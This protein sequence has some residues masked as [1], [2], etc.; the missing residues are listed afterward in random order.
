MPHSLIL[1]LSKRDI[2]SDDEQRLLLAIFNKGQRFKAGDEIIADGSRPTTSLILSD[3]LVG[4][5]KVLANGT[6]Q[7]T[8]LH[9]PGDF[10][11]LHGFLLKKMPHGVV[12]FTNSVIT[13]VD[14]SALRAITE[15]AP[16][17][18]RMLWL[19]TLIDGS[20]HRE[21]IVRMGRLQATAQ[22][23]HLLCELYVRLDIVG[24][25]QNATFA[26]PLTQSAIADILGLSVVH[27]NRSIQ[28]LRRAQ[29]VEWRDFQV[30]VLNWERL[31][32]IAEFEPTYLCLQREPR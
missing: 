13:P 21:W 23:A 31:R 30:R 32:D 2:L 4:R 17:L 6:R 14:H 26:L 25:A 15:K 18:A 9:V 3:G 12:A 8:A 27:A 22:V 19:L 10:L 20:I 16:H 28:Q 24:L 5:S 29:V 11:D 7:I 1:Q